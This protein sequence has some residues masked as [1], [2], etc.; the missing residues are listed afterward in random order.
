[1][2]TQPFLQAQIKEKQQSSASLAFVWGIHRWPVNSP[3]KWPVTRKM[4]PFDDVIMCRI[5][6]YPIVLTFL[7]CGLSGRAGTGPWSLG[8]YRGQ[9]WFDVAQSCRGQTLGSSSTSP[10][11][12]QSYPKIKTWWCHDID[13][14]SS[15]LALCEENRSL[16]DCPRKT[17]V[18]QSF[19]IVTW[20]SCWKKGQ[21]V[22]NE[23]SWRSC[24]VTP[25]AFNSL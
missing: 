7:H 3:H 6:N 5:H 20:I 2:F 14:L 21:F 1:M 12:Y 10:L 16:V 24:C 19:V 17:L 23:T 9:T 13:P 25:M 11:I 4:F 15:L 8:C 22:G 18:I